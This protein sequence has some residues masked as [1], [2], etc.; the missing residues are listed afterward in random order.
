MCSSDLAFR[1]KRKYTVDFTC[2]SRRIFSHGL[3]ELVDL[4][5]RIPQSVRVRNIVEE[6]LGVQCAAEQES[7]IA[8]CRLDNV[9]Y[10][11]NGF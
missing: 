3:S 7:K 1:E 8:I 10:E 9:S 6:F 11:I 5:W 4:S 2:R